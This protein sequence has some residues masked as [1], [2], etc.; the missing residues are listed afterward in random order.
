M[1][2]YTHLKNFLNFGVCGLKAKE[3]NLNLNALKN[4]KHAKLDQIAD[5]VIEHVKVCKESSQWKEGYEPAPLTYLNQAGTRTIYLKMIGRQNKDE[6]HKR[7]Y[8]I[9]D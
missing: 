8:F 1:K 3:N 4:G 5:K 9:K 6:R 2:Q 7:N